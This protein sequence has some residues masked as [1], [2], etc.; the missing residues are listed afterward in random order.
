M[1]GA[2]QPQTRVQR[3]SSARWAAR[4]RRHAGARPTPTPCARAGGGRAASGGAQGDQN[5]CFRQAISA[6]RTTTAHSRARRTDGLV[7]RGGTLTVSDAALG[8]PTSREA[9]AA[10]GKT[11]TTPRARKPS[12][13]RCGGAQRRTA[14]GSSWRAHA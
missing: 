6:T 3:P 5:H 1:A 2:R 4:F 8:G 14:A 13:A 10:L 12:S 7:A 9:A 11:A